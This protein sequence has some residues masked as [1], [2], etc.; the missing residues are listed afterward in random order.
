MAPA[1]ILT[2][3]V[4]PVPLGP[5]IPTDSPIF[6][7]P[8]VMSSLNSPKSFFS[9]LNEMRSA[10]CQSPLGGVASNSMG[11]SLNLMFSSGRYPS[12]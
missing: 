4:F 9:W 7:D 8:P 2:K 3:V 5:T 11:L 10:V 12:R 6:T 1:R